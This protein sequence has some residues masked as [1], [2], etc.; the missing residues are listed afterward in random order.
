MEIFIIDN[1]QDV[2]SILINAVLIY[3]SIILLTRLAG[4]RAYS[5]M[6][7]FDFA[8]TIAIG[9]VVA[10]GI[11]LSDVGLVRTV[12]TLVCLLSLQWIAS[13]L[14]SRSNYFEKL[15]TNK[16]I[17]LI[18]NGAVL[19]DNLR[20]A[21]LSTDELYMELR[22]AGLHSIEEV[23]IAIM[24]TTADVSIIKKEAD[25]EIDPDILQGVNR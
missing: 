11:L 15:L 24:E 4:V 22:M 16:P 5:K 1:W 19:H 20:K 17:T 14:V 8:I 12:F 23:A 6:T 21:R 25:K 3:G 7:T 2:G 18:Y 9:S 13:S 10:S